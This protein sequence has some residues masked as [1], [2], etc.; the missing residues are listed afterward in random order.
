VGRFGEISK[1]Y[2]GGAR[3]KRVR[4]AMMVKLRRHELYF[5]REMEMEK[6][7]ADWQYDSILL[8][9]V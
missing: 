6:P 1:I 8:I 5:A 4:T 3:D 7:L 9:G 2:R